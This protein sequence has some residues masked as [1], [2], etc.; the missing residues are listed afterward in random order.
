MQEGPRL[1]SALR[2]TQDCAQ[3]SCIQSRQ[4]CVFRRIPS[5]Y[6]S[7]SPPRISLA[8]ATR[9]CPKPLVLRAEQLCIIRRVTS[10]HASLSRSLRSGAPGASKDEICQ[11]SRAYRANS[12][13]SDNSSFADGI[14]P[15]VAH[16]TLSSHQSHISYK[17]CRDS[18]NGLTDNV[19][20]GTPYLL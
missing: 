11:C 4:L 3:D 7:R 14:L 16:R 18:R 19:K 13:L 1:E 5:S 9:L 12:Y 20:I 6:A 10:L 2:P 17:E 15:S 8:T